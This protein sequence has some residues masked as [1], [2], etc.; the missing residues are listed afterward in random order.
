MGRR[1]VEAY[2]SATALSMEKKILGRGPILNERRWF[3]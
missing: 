1:S 3:Y 2:R